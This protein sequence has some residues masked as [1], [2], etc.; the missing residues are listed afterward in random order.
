MTDP[1]PHAS[2]AAEGA[3]DADVSPVPTAETALT[4]ALAKAEEH[5]AQYLRAVAEIENV[6][7]RA[8]RDVEQARNFAIERFAQELLPALDSFE[9]AIANAPT[10]DLKGLLEG[11]EATHRLLQKAFDKA[12]VT[13]LD[14]TGKPFN[15]AE[16]EAMVAA[17][18][19]EHAPDTVLQT[20]QKGYVLNGRLLRP[21]RVIVS[22]AADA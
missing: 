10:S 21:A 14:P 18:S 20:V 11:Q 19:S 12:G 17:P 9:L 22:R 16:H 5:Y 3:S 4:A 13:V 2:P 6:R 1:T 7:K 15:P 8:A